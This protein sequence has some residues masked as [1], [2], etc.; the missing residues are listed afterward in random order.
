VRRKYTLTVDRLRASQPL[1]C[2]QLL[3]DTTLV[4]SLLLDLANIGADASRGP[5]PANTPYATTR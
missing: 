5:A 4:R 1:L 3:L 2:P